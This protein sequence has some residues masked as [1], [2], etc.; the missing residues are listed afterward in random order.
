LSRGVWDSRGNGRRSAVGRAL[1]WLQ[2]KCFVCRIYLKADDSVC[3]LDTSYW[4]RYCQMPLCNKDRRQPEL[5]REL[6]CEGEHSCPSSH[7][8][9]CSGKAERGFHQVFPEEEQ[10]NIH[11]RH[12]GR[13][14]AT[15]PASKRRKMNPSPAPA[16]PRCAARAV[17]EP[18]AQQQITSPAS[19]LHSVAEET[20]AIGTLPC[21]GGRAMPISLK[22]RHL[23]PCLGLNCM[24]KR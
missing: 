24:A 15:A 3:Y 2:R 12:N 16:S 19:V 18:E 20:H 21:R 23:S 14:A 22:R 6:T 10:V 5:G 17:P 7:V 11:P 4:C 8:F 9:R 1:L 13:A